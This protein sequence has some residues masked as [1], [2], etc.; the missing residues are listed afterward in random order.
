MCVLSAVW[1]M[2]SER[3]EFHQLY[4]YY[5]IHSPA[6]KPFTF[7]P[8]NLSSLVSHTP[9]TVALFHFIPQNEVNKIS[10]LSANI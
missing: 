8:A 10:S 2:R 4:L 6:K 1:R 3:E 5:I 7:I 9:T